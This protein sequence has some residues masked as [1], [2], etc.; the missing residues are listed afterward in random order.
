M[1]ITAVGQTK[2]IGEKRIKRGTMG[3]KR[4]QRRKCEGLAQ[5]NTAEKERKTTA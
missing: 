4:N 3:A 5:E 1:R 2:K